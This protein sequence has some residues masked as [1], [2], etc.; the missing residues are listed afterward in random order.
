MNSLKKLYQNRYGILNFVRPTSYYKHPEYVRK[1]P[2]NK[3]Q[4][5]RLMRDLRLW[6]IENAPWSNRVNIYYS[7]CAK[8]QQEMNSITR[9]SK[10]F[11][12]LFI[13]VMIG[14]IVFTLV[15]FIIYGRMRSEFWLKKHA[16][17]PNDTPLVYWGTR[18]LQTVHGRD[19]AHPALTEEQ[20]EAWYKTDI[21]Q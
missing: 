11:N 10:I 21:Y 8:I 6:V 2:L 18:G 7:D 12:L 3:F 4:Q 1:E 13:G 16:M 20:T 9:K 14:A 19:K 17:T 5:L 15:N